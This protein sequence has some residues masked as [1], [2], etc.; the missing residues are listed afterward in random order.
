MITVIARRHHEL[1]PVLHDE[2]G[3]YRHKVFIKHLGWQL[4][5][6]DALPGR[7]FDQ[8]DHADTRYII[9]LDA[10][11]RVHGC[12][13]L[14]PTS[15]PYLMS[16]VFGFL[17]DRAVPRR[18]D[19][20]EISR[21]AASSLENGKLPMRVF[22]NSLHNAW[23]LGATEVVA[24]TTPALERYFLR[25]GVQ[26]SRL[27]QPQRVNR[28]HV[29]ALSFPAYQKNGRA[30]L[31]AQSAAVASLNQAFLR[32]GSALAHQAERP[33]AYAVSE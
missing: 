18:S 5:A 11:Q 21:F 31:H 10:L 32:A 12:A 16:E 3:C 27:G 4:D 19:T 15:Q 8:F 26:L 13:R 33:Q 6:G 7:E 25:H 28:D 23:A 1:T 17:C 22:W 29:V 30:A 14:L 9:A 20:W 24:V 2:L